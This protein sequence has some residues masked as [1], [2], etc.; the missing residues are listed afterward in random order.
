MTD[1]SI[2]ISYPL[3]YCFNNDD[4]FIKTEEGY[5]EIY[6]SKKLR[7]AIVESEDLAEK[8]VDLMNWAEE[9]GKINKECIKK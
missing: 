3:E 2:N 5:Y 1:K 7:V 6:D 9:D 8:I 4:S